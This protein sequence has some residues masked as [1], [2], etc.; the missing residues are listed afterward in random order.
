MIFAH[1]GLVT[2][3]SPENTIASLEAAYQAGFRKIEFDLWFLDEALL[4]KHDKPEGENLP[5]LREYLRF[6]NEMT[7]WLDFKNLDQSNA[8]ATFELAFSEIK[9]AKIDLRKIFLATFVLDREL[10]VRAR[11]IFGE[12]VQFIAACGDKDE[13]VE[14]E[15]LC[16]QNQ[17]KFISIFHELIDADFVKRFS[18]QEIFAWTVNDVKRLKELEDLGVKYFAS[19]SLPNR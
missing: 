16:L 13:I 11:E 8:K 10:I 15:N 12:D 7:Y 1:R 4:V 5:T 14:L 17:V 3:N 6:G 9:K 19:D 18:A 2:K